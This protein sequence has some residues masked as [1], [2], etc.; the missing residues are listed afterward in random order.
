M[1]YKHNHLYI[2]DYGMQLTGP[3]QL[4]IYTCIPE[5]IGDKVSESMNKAGFGIVY[6]SLN[7]KVIVNIIKES[8]NHSTIIEHKIGTSSKVKTNLRLFDNICK[9]HPIY[10]KLFPNGRKHISIENS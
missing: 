7:Q 1:L 9:T 6:R 8:V 10:R 3:D 4:Y 5:K 2:V